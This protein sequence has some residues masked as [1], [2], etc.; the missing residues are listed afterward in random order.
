MTTLVSMHGHRLGRLPS[1]QRHLARRLQLA[2]Y[3]DLARLP[4]IPASYAPPSDYTAPMDLNDQYGDCTAAA[5]AHIEGQTSREESGTELQFADQ[6]ILDFYFLCSGGQDVG[7]DMGTC[8][9]NWQTVGIGGQKIVAYAALEPGNL[10]QLRAVIWLFKGGAYIGGGLPDR[11][12]PAGGNW[13]RIDWTGTASPNQNNGHCVSVP[14]FTTGDLFGVATWGEKGHLMDG[15]FY[16]SIFDEPY[17]VITQALLAT[18]KS[19]DGFDLAG[20]LQDVSDITGLPPT[21]IPP[22]P[23]PPPKPSCLSKLVGR[24]AAE[25]I[26]RWQQRRAA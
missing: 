3:L 23:P 19:P 11:V 17:L 24:Q 7:A 8:L 15:A 4:A 2:N 18:G 16:A 6:Q 25:Q 20:L 1:S 26:G 13:S 14:S 21:P 12:V 22:T 5:A 10:A 9:K